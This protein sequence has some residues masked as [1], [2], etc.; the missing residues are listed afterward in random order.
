[1]SEKPDILSVPT[2]EEIDLALARLF[3]SDNPAWAVMLKLRADRDRW[4]KGLEGI[5]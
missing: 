2:E 5:E 3:F 1:M 4:K